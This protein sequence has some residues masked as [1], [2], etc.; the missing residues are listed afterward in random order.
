MHESSLIYS[1]SR[2]RISRCLV[3]NNI[4]SV[5]III[6]LLPSAL[7]AWD[8]LFTHLIIYIRGC[9]TTYECRSLTPFYHLMHYCSLWRCG[10]SIHGLFHVRH[11]PICQRSICPALRHPCAFPRLKLDLSWEREGMILSFKPSRARPRH[12]GIWCYTIFKVSIMKYAYMPF[13]FPFRKPASLADG[14][15]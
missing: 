2:R 7:V 15:E 4:I 3:G 14:R 5:R 11:V 10:F 12:K 13:L 8:Y 9:I 6:R 1:A